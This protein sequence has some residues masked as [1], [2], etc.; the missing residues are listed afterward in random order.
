MSQSLQISS[1]FCFILFLI[2]S[3]A[4]NQALVYLSLL[5]GIVPCWGVA[6]FHS[7]CWGLTELFG[8]PVGCKVEQGGEGRSCQWPQLP[9]WCL[10]Q[11]SGCLSGQARALGRERK[12]LRTVGTARR[13]RGLPPMGAAGALGSRDTRRCGPSCGFSSL[14]AHS[15]CWEGWGSSGAR[16]HSG[17]QRIL[18][19]FSFLSQSRRSECPV[20]N[21]LG[22]SKLHQA[23]KS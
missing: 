1:S 4:S 13:E 7:G 3:A 17:N 8:F 2:R 14:S 20:Q 22:P 9:L 5:V 10:C 6:R 21:S 19:N 16:P 18:I 15:P 12:K 23:L 11:G